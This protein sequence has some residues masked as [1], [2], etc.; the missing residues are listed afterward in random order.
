MMHARPLKGI[1]IKTFNLSETNKLKSNLDCRLKQEE[2]RYKDI[3]RCLGRDI[4][5]LRLLDVGCGTGTFLNYCAKQGVDYYGLEP[6]RELYDECINKHCLSRQKVLNNKLEDN[7]FSFNSFDIIVLNHVLEHTEKPLDFL[8]LCRKYLK[9]DGAVYLEVPNESFLM[10]KMGFRKILCMYSGTPTNIDHK[11]LFTQNTLKRIAEKTGFEELRIW[12]KSLWGDR[13]A[14]KIVTGK[15]SIGP[16]LYIAAAFFKLTRLD[17]LLRQGTL[18]GL[19][20]K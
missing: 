13:N 3:S 9:E 15:E 5:S 4:S 16:V 8:R 18:V 19:A 14:I 7:K 20:F 2:K 10:L 11:S 1:D 17:L 12:Q 6:D